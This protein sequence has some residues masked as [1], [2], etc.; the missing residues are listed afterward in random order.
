[1]VLTIEIWYGGMN[2][3]KVDSDSSVGQI[4]M[5]YISLQTGEARKWH[6]K[7]VM[8]CAMSILALEET[9][10]LPSNAR[11]IYNFTLGFR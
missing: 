2:W 6:D 3:V 9:R 4:D 7:H 8:T 10:Y 1:M 11:I 5:N